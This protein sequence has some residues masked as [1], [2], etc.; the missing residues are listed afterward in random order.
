ME[1]PQGGSSLGLGDSMMNSFTSPSEAYE[2]LRGTEPKAT[3]WLVP[4]LVTFALAV[5]F[6]FMLSSNQTFRT[7]ITDTQT[8]AMQKRVDQGKMTQDQFEKAQEGMEKM[9]SLFLVFGI[10]GSAV[11]LAFAY[12]G[13]ALF[14]WLGGKMILKSTAGYGKNLEIYGV[15][16]WIGVLATVVTILMANALNSMYAT[17]SLS[18]AVYSTFDPL[19]PMHRFLSSI[20]FFGI[21]QWAVI[22]I[23]LAKTSGKPV[24]TAVGV[25]L[26]LYVLL[27][28]CKLGWGM[29]FT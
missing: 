25:S 3:L 9:S 19:N 13:G 4:L 11:V 7:Q 26:G 21:W 1:T 29:M 28:L 12:F 6:V 10:V 17:P 8:K 16:S 27:I 5:L 20:E 23:G 15:A 14:L 22:G 2:K 24:G 18:I